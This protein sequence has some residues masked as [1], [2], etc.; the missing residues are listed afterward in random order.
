MNDPIFPNLF[1]DW[2]VCSRAPPGSSLASKK[3][4]VHPISPARTPTYPPRQAGEG[5]FILDGQENRRPLKNCVNNYLS[6]DCRIFTRELKP[7]NG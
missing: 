3:I 6:K 1:D 2:D 4:I 7:R 5:V